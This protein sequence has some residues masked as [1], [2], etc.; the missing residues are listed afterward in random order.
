M[1]HNQVGRVNEVVFFPLKTVR[2]DFFLCVK[3][4]EGEI[5]AGGKKFL[6]KGFEPK[7]FLIS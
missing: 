6:P 3:K 2:K 1:E 5:A 4:C 7:L